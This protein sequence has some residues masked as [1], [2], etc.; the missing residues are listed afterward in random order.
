L[1]RPDTQQALTVNF[2]EPGVY[3]MEAQDEE[4]TVHAEGTVTVP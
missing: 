3:R 4:G 2:V 1:V